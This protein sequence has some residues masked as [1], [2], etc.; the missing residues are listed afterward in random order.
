MDC[1][2]NVAGLLSGFRPTRESNIAELIRVSEL[3]FKHVSSTADTAA[4]DE[5]KTA[6][7]GDATAR[8]TNNNDNDI[9]SQVKRIKKGLERTRPASIRNQPMVNVPICTP[10]SRGGSSSALL[11]SASPVSPEEGANIDSVTASC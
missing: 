10:V 2:L 1:L 11:C 4:M 3:S 9:K 8:T 6:K 5:K 7:D